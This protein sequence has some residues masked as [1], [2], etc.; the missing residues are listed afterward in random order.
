MPDLPE[1]AVQADVERAYK[2]GISVLEEYQTE[3]YD[4]LR[5]NAARASAKVVKALFEAGL[6]VSEEDIRADER[7]K[8]AERFRAF[9]RRLRAVS[10][11]GLTLGQTWDRDT[12]AMEY[13]RLADVIERGDAIDP[14]RSD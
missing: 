10:D 4:D 13:D 8:V 3:P 7:R 12:R 2:V 6:M 9:A 14:R 5:L 1:E 11:E